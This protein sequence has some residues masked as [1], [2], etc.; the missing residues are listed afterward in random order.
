MI[1]LKQEDLGGTVVKKPEKK[2]L[3]INCLIFMQFMQVL[4][5]LLIIKKLVYMAVNKL[6]KK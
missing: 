3:N 4:D 2:E 6:N 1:P 5:V